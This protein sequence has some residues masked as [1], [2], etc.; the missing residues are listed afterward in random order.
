MLRGIL[1]TYAETFVATETQV[2]DTFNANASNAIKTDLA[3]NLRSKLA[4]QEN[5]AIVFGLA[6]IAQVLRKHNAVPIQ[7]FTAFRIDVLGHR[8]LALGFFLIN[9]T[10]DHL[11][12]E[13]LPSQDADNA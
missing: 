8:N 4:L 7:N 5:T 9:A 1:D 6:R 12:I 3:Q 13:S 10:V 2:E 11:D